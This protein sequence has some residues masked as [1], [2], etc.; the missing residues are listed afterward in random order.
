MTRRARTRR[1]STPR[2]REFERVFDEL[3]VAGRDAVRS[4]RS[5]E[6]PPRALSASLDELAVA[7]RD[8]SDALDRG[9]GFEAAAER[10]D[11]AACPVAAN[12]VGAGMSERLVA[13]QVEA[14]A[15]GVARASRGERPA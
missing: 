4:V 2:L 15:A 13:G 8:L 9:E 3:R 7:V 6:P 12:G 11:R 10:A 1:G 5:D 14:L